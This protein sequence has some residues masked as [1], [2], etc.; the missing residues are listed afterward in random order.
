MIEWIVGGCMFVC[1]WDCGCACVIVQ[2]WFASVIR[3][4]VVFYMDAHEF[5]NVN[6]QS[7]DIIAWSK[8]PLYLC[9]EAT[10]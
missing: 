7:Y 9:R 4:C 10:N 3:K 1:V 6:I 5:N 8:L 2:V